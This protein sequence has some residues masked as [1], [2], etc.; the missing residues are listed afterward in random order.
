MHEIDKI[1]KV[2]MGGECGG[3]VM[4]PAHVACEQ[5]KHKR[6][7]FVNIKQIILLSNAVD[8]ESTF[9]GCKA[10]FI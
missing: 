7:V 1:R 6:R 4:L 9:P 2:C 3:T 10:T 8:G 5:R